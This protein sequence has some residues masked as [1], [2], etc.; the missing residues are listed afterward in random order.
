MTLT[1]Y[2][3][4]SFAVAGGLVYHAVKTREQYFPAMLYLS[5]SKLSVVVLGNLAFALTLVLGHL[6]KTMFLG[7]LREAEVERLIRTGESEAM[8]KQAILE[9]GRGETL[10]TVMEIQERHE[11]IKELERSLLELNSIFLDMAVLVEAQGEVL[12]NIDYQVSKSVEYTQKG[13]KTL[14][15]VK[16]MQK[17]YRRVS[18]AGRSA[19]NVPSVGND[20]NV[21]GQRRFV[22][23]ARSP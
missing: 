16:E 10:A 21:R 5:T 4:G 20:V 12:N 3:V 19:R 13:T 15:E 7:T 6:L 14:G 23:Q 18:S 22:L 17:Q 9:K 2:V 8:F 1:K 11:A